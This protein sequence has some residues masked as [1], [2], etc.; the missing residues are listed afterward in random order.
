VAPLCALALGV[1]LAFTPAGARSAEIV[2]TEPVHGFSFSP[3]YVAMRKGY[4]KDEG[5]DVKLVTTAGTEFVSAVVNGQAFAFIG[6][7]DHNAFAAANGKALKAVSGL[8]AHAN[9]YLMARKDLL[10]V[11]TDLPTFL[12]G[13][14]VARNIAAGGQAGGGSVLVVSLFRSLERARYT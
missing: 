4:F 12:E 9:I 6:S 8:V 10:P 2:I 11:T 5:L 7:V 14:R 1:A 3:V 13:K